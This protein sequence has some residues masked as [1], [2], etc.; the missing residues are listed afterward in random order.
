MARS[1]K[2]WYTVQNMYSRVRN[3]QHKI[4]QQAHVT[5]CEKLLKL[6]KQDVL[7]Y[8]VHS[9]LLEYTIQCHYY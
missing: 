2:K 6:L 1:I 7:K 5:P 8:D 3:C 9:T 4:L